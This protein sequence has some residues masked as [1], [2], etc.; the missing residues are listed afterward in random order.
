MILYCGG[1][2]Y[3]RFPLTVCRGAYILFSCPSAQPL[4]FGPCLAGVGGVGGGGGGG[5]GSNK[6]CLLIFLVFCLNLICFMC[7]S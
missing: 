4:H 5:G 6:H 1:I 2:I 3:T 7:N